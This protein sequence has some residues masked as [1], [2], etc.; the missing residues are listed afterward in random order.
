[1]SLL[2]KPYIIE[3]AEAE[4]FPSSGEVLATLSQVQFFRNSE[5]IGPE[6]LALHFVSGF[7]PLFDSVIPLV[8]IAPQ[9]V[10]VAL[11]TNSRGD[12]IV[13]PYD[14]GPNERSRIITFHHTDT[15]SS[16]GLLLSNNTQ[17]RAIY[18]DRGF[19]H[20]GTGEGGSTNICVVYPDGKASDDQEKTVPAYVIAFVGM[21]AM[22]FD[23]Q[24]TQET[25]ENVGGVVV[26]D[27]P[28]E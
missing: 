9:D 1:M 13:I 26:V 24:S 22:F 23:L 25:Y 15:I 7:G 17:W 28:V 16:H 4:E 10:P 11:H 12:Q 2:E 6:A 27:A 19:E 20:D 8:I 5:A 14:H 18:V 21:D 3:E